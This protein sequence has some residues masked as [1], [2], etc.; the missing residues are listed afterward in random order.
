MEEDICKNLGEDNEGAEPLASSDWSRAEH[1]EEEVP[2]CTCDYTWLA[3][4]YA[5]TIQCVQ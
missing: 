3:I 2:T 1:Q 4:R 5:C